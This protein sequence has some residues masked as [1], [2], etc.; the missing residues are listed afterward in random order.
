MISDPALPSPAPHPVEG[1]RVRRFH[2][3]GLT[4]ASLERSVAFYRDVLGFDMVVSWNPRAPYIGTLVGYPD[5]DLHAAV[6]ALPGSDGRLELLE[7]RNAVCEPVDPDNGRAGVAHIA[8]Y[9]DSLDDLY[10]R[11]SEAGVA[12]VSTP[13]TPTIGPNIG[14]RAVYMIDPDGVRVELIETGRSFDDFARE[15]R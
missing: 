10:A 15:S 8:F 13:V 7:Y 4:V 3:I 6:L 1:P 2:H 14:G 9:V 12:S 5:V 11:L